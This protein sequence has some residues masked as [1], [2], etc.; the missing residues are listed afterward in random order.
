[1]QNKISTCNKICF[2]DMSVPKLVPWYDMYDSYGQV[3]GINPFKDDNDDWQSMSS[4]WQIIKSDG[5]LRVWVVQRMLN[6]I[7]NVRSKS[8]LNRFSQ[9][10][11]PKGNCLYSTSIR[12][13][14]CKYFGADDWIW[15][16]DLEFTI[17]SLYQLSYIG[18][19]GI[20]VLFISMQE[21]FLYFHK[22][23]FELFF[24]SL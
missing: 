22:D 23:F 17:L 15:T 13:F 3:S 18:M 20:I 8:Q 14:D 2:Q 5:S 4:W 6:D 16:S 9:L 1:M 19:W 11:Q 21:V 10:P 24:S 12:I 7:T